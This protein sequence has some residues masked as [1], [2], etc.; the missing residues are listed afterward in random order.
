GK[1][2][3]PPAQIAARRDQA[4]FAE[5]GGQQGEFILGE[6]GNGLTSIAV[7]S[8]VT[9]LSIREIQRQTPLADRLYFKVLSKGDA[10]PAKEGRADDFRWR[11]DEAG[12]S[13]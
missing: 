6:L 7:I 12:Q 11:G 8:P 13:Q 9:D 5:S 2:E 3:L 1:P 10:L 4:A